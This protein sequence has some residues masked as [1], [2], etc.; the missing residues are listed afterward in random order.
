M[1]SDKGMDDMDNVD[2]TKRESVEDWS[3]WASDRQWLGSLREGEEYPATEFV[4]WSVSGAA[5]A[6]ADYDWITSYLYIND[7]RKTTELFI[8]HGLEGSRML[9]QL[10]DSIKN[11]QIRRERAEQSLASWRKEN[12]GS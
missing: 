10:L 8:P 7:G 5:E 3:E 1:V 11:L 4:A 6:K 2:D 12:G 9:D